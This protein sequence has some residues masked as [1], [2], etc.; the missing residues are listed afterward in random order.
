MSEDELRAMIEDELAEDA[1]ELELDGK[2][3]QTLGIIEPDVSLS[4]LLLAVYGGIAVGLY[5]AD[6]ETLAVRGDSSRFGPA[7]ELTVVHEVTHSLQQMRYDI[8]GMLD[9]AEGNSDL[10]AALTGL[11]EGDASITETLYEIKSFSERQ[12]QR[13]EE[14]YA[15]VDDS[16]YRAAPAFIRRVISFPYSSGR[17]FAIDLY[18]L[19]GSYA[20][21]DAAYAAPPQS[22][23]QVLHF[24][25]YITEDPAG[26]P[27]AVELPDVE[28]ALGEGWSE[29]KR[30]AMG[31]LFF[32]ALLLGEADYEDAQ[33]AAA[34]W[35]GD[36]YA[37]LEGP[38]GDHA[39]AS[40]S[41]WDT[42][43]DAAEFGDAIRRYLALNDVFYR[44]AVDEATATVRL[45]VVRDDADGATEVLDGIV[46]ILGD[47]SEE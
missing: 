32:Q 31:E 8:D 20:A 13:A 46:G 30:D 35:G 38:S 39:V 9:D 10:Q 41:V 17:N 3:Y 4:E 47:R 7:E 24:E 40:L 6:D 42:P 36:A 5:D 2:L 33:T 22:T 11:I 43:E 28:A 45:A 21:I 14:A 19:N 34:G 23:E 26:V 27:V 25:L 29:L 18:L 37:L 44:V 1:D 12:S 15:E 16:A